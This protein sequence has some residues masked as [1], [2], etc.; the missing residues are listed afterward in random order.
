MLLFLL[1]KAVVNTVV[2]VSCLT[3]AAKRFPP[4]ED[5]MVEIH[6]L[7]AQGV[8]EIHLLGQNVNDYQGEME[9]GQL[10]DL[11]FL[12]HELLILSGHTYTLY[13]FTHLH[14]AIG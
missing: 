13:H 5:I 10:A 11:A 12:I 9:N 14:L 3:H 7:A 6:A 4:Y 1:W 2:T 8:R